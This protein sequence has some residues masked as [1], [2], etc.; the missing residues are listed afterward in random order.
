MW[1][2]E[3]AIR[4]GSAI[5]GIFFDEGQNACRPTSGSNAWADLY[6][7]I[8]EDVET[9]HRGAMTV[10]NPGTVVPQCYEETADTLVTFE[11]SYSDHVNAYTRLSWSSTIPSKSGP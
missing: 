6:G 11:G 4:S 9:D 7:Q 8:N 2:I 5:S 3:A 1:D 10:I